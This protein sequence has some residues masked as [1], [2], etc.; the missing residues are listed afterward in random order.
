MRSMSRA[1]LWYMK[2]TPTS[3]LGCF[4]ISSALRITS[5]FI[6]SSSSS[7]LITAIACETSSD[8]RLARLSL[9]ICEA[10]FDIAVT[11]FSRSHG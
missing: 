6:A 1:M 3:L 2:R 4:A 11:S 9:S 7:R 10:I 5:M 8:M